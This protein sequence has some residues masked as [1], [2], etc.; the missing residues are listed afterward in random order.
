VL[1]LQTLA[2]R[3]VEIGEK[4]DA[5][6]ECGNAAERSKARGVVRLRR[7][8]RL[9]RRHGSSLCPVPKPFAE[10]HEDGPGRHPRSFA[11]RTASLA[12]VLEPF[13]I[14]GR[15]SARVRRR[16]RRSHGVGGGW[17]R[18]AS[19]QGAGDHHRR[20]S[21]CCLLKNR[22]GVLRCGRAMGSHVTSIGNRFGRV[23]SM[24]HNSPVCIPSTVRQG[25]WHHGRVG[26][27]P[28]GRISPHRE[29]EERQAQCGRGAFGG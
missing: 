19:F 8:A 6:S 26:W 22:G 13:A 21:V 17:T 2:N 7:G 24:R 18:R 12:P 16:H 10:P 15:A 9:K 29:R 1:H 11:R 23:C 28:N 14:V 3:P 5:C 27:P 25:T 4:G 20:A